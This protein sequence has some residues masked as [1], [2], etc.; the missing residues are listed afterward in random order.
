MLWNDLMTR[1][2]T[3]ENGESRREGLDDHTANV[4]NLKIHDQA[5]KCIKM[6]NT[7]REME[8]KMER[9]KARQTWFVIEA[10]LHLRHFRTSQSQN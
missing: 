6:V 8:N 4:S 5:I 1:R 2:R 3:G 9:T 10:R 7:L